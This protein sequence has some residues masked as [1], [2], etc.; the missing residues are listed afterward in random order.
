MGVILSVKG[1]RV[2]FF[3]GSSELRAIRGIDLEL[4]EGEVLALVGES[5]SG[6]SVTSKAILGILPHNARVI[7]GEV[8]YGGR[9]L[10]SL[11]ESELMRVRGREIAMVPQDPF[12]SLDPICRVGYQIAESV[13]SEGSRYSRE[14]RRRRAVSLMH[15]V[16]IVDAE[17][18]YY[19]YPFRFSG[20]MRQRIAIAAALATSPR[21]LICDE[22]TTAL[23]VTI[24]A[25]ILDLIESLKRE[26]GLSVIFI[27]HDL[28]VV[29]RIADRVA[30]MYAGK[31]VEVGKVD[32]V[33]Y[34]P[35]HPYT[36]ALMSSVPSGSGRLATIPGGVP[37]MKKPITG[38][39]FA[40]RSEYAMKIDYLIEPP[41]FDISETHKV[42]SWLYHPDAPKSD[43]PKRLSEIIG[44]RRGERER[45][46]GDEYR[47]G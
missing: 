41:F 22:P 14:E 2:S 15:E 20:G 7:S 16:G 6:K 34:N 43:M 18:R 3:D 47:E 30:V 12:L 33:F 29:A 25:Q 44:G 24:E 8:M 39:A 42:A 31:I 27:T 17:K 37:D 4:N 1:L 32:E 13:A 21:V 46:C 28:G 40:P 36:W 9:N 35:K 23:D 45:I 38:D 26:R 11:G 5:G 10:L 19:D